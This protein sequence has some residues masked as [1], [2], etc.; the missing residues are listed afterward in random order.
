MAKTVL[1]RELEYIKR[2][3]KNGMVQVKVWVP[4]EKADAI[5]L[6]A[7]ELRGHEPHR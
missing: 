7:I 2:M 4:K 6:K 3:K 1:E 5:K